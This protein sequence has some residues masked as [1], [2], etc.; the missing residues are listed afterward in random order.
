LGD[1]TIPDMMSAGWLEIWKCS[2]SARC[3]NFDFEVA[4]HFYC[5]SCCN[6]YLPCSSSIYLVHW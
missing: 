1:F 2:C 4:R 3:C 6:F 5:I